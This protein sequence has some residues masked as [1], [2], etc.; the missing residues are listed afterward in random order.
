MAEIEG[1]DN[2]SKD[3]L[4]DAFKALLANTSKKEEEE[5]YSVSYFT[6]IKVLSTKLLVPYI[7][8]LYAKTL[9]NNLNNQA[10]IHQLTTRL[11]S[12]PKD[13]LTNNFTTGDISKY[14]SNYFYRIVINTRAS[15]YSTT[16]YRQ[17]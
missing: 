16:K 8:I 9:V 12:K 4:G 11:P 10:L 15:K 14:S 5:Q 17:F 7:V 1:K 2:T 13:K 3:N 6:S